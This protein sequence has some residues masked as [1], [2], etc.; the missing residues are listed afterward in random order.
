MFQLISSSK[1]DT[2]GPHYNEPSLQRHSRK[3]A[4]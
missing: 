4:I 2:V 1:E 3:T